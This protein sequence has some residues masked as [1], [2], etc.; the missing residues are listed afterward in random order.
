M[1]ESPLR[2]FTRNLKEHQVFGNSLNRKMVVLI[3]F[4]L[5]IGEPFRF[6]ENKKFNDSVIH[7]EPDKSP[8]FIIGHWRSGTTFTHRLLSQDPAF[9]FQNK[10]ANFFSDNFLTTEKYFKPVLS[11]F[12]DFVTPAK[13]WKNN[14]SKTMDLDTPSE[15]DTALMAEISE[16]TYHWAHLFPKSYKE[17]FDKYLFLEDIS[18]EELQEWKQTMKTLFN[19]V[20]LKN[21]QGRLLIKN[22]GDTARIK[23]LLDLYP[24]AKFIFLHRNP[25]E[26]FYSNIK[27]WSHVMNT[28]ALQK[29]SEEE[30]KEIVLN[31]YRKLHEKYFEQKHLLNSDQLVEVSH[32]DL[33]DNPLDTLH[34]IYEKLNLQGFDNALPYFENHVKKY[35]SRKKS[36][37]SYNAEDIR[38]INKRWDPVFRAWNYSKLTPDLRVLDLAE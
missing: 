37:Y 1:S 21:Q 32:Q 19:K 7:T 2:T 27:L 25:Y 24:N 10:Y 31:V 16:V 28:V 11:K 13:R 36:V 4:K 38:E 22:P 23:H 5:L 30:K 9:F 20:Y 15:S 3:Y 17:Y 8:V 33:F 35:S 6:I 12:I 14:I 18:E 29:I 34:G 26:V